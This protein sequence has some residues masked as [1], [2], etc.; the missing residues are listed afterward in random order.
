MTSGRPQFEHVGLC[1]AHDRH[2]VPDSLSLVE[3]GGEC[4]HVRKPR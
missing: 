3:V 2:G 1:Y 4:L